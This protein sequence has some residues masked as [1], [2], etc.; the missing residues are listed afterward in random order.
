MN[1]ALFVDV[2][3]PNINGVVTH[4]AMLRESLTKLGHN[5]LIDRLYQAKGQSCGT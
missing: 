4:V 3:F 1:I 2:Y 5:V